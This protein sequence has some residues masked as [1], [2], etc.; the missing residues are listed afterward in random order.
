MSILKKRILLVTAAV[1]LPGGVLI[2]IYG[3]NWWLMKRHERK[4]IEA[5]RLV[6]C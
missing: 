3:V 1:L 6:G 2:G 4:I 5:A